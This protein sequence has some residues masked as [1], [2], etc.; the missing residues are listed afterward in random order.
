MDIKCPICREPWDNDTIHDYAD[1]ASST[2]AEISKVFRTKGCGVA[3]SAWSIPCEKAEGSEMLS[4]LAD[5]LGD[6][7]DGYASMVEDLGL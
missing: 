7:I 2:Y 4:A 3:F 6:D 1:E 5:L